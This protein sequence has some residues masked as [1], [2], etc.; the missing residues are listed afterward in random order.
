M[1]VLTI[2]GI[3]QREFF[4]SGLAFICG[5]GA[6]IGSALAYV[7]DQRQEFNQVQGDEMQQLFGVRIPL[8]RPEL[9]FRLESSDDSR[10]EI[11]QY[12]MP[13][14]LV[15]TIAGGG[16][17]PPW[18]A[19]PMLDEDLGPIKQAGGL[20]AA[21]GS[22]GA[23]VA[24]TFSAAQSSGNSFCLRTEPTPERF[25]DLWVVDLSDLKLYHVVKRRAK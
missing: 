24:G 7:G 1:A 5:I 2:R 10:L 3:R 4:K 6:I 22:A 13:G 16:S 11:R 20:A 23:L 19:C 25:W 9:F 8:G 17:L 21:Q 12:S 18:R 15:E 14:E